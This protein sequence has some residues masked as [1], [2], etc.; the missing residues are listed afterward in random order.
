MTT[1]SE[2]RL[3]GLW[4]RLVAWASETHDWSGWIGVDSTMCKV[5]AKIG[6]ITGYGHTTNEA[7]N[8]LADGLAEEGWPDDR[9]TCDG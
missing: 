5:A 4:C 8:N 3:E 2:R 1:Q 7:I 9:E 6:P